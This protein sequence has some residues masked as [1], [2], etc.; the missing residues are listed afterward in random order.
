MKGIQHRTYVSHFGCM[1]MQKFGVSLDCL[2]T[3]DE[4]ALQWYGL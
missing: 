3:S 2:Q 4:A 1:R